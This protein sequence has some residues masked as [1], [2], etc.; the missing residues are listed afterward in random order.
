MKTKLRL[1]SGIAALGALIGLFACEMPE[2][3]TVK[4]K[5]QMVLP[6]GLIDPIELM[7]DEDDESTDFT[8]FLDAEEIGKKL[9]DDFAGKVYHYKSKDAN[10][11]YQTENIQTYLITYPVIKVDLDLKEHIQNMEIP[12]A[13]AKILLPGGMNT[14]LVAASEYAPVLPEIDLGSI[15]DLI[16]DIKID[17]GT[18]IRVRHNDWDYLNTLKNCI[19]ISIPQ[20]W[21]VAKSGIL[22]GT[23]DDDDYYLEFLTDNTDV[24]GG[25]YLLQTTASGP[26]PSYDTDGI[27]ISVIFEPNETL[28]G[29]LGNRGAEFGGRGGAGKFL[30][31]PSRRGGG[32]A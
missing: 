16:R 21:N 5:P 7:K 28:P 8:K 19:T 32:A 3:V 10:D 27:K 20:F 15:K 9:G 13:S 18:G 1:M 29:S 14:N 2:T 25:R 12:E 22:V 4:A 6:I 23:A 30:P 24:S 11:G 17:E 26:L 31:P